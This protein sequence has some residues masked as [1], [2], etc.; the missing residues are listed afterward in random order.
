MKGKR[1]QVEF[2]S[3]FFRKEHVLLAAQE[4]TS[5][6][7]VLVD[8]SPDRTFA[9]LIPKEGDID[10]KLVED[11]FYNYVLSVTKNFQFAG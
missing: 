5:S 10:P 6:F 3:N 4:Y 1:I 7:W 9:V 11:E 2:D 8:G